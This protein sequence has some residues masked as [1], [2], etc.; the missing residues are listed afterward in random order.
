MFHH[1]IMQNQIEVADIRGR[2]L[3][4]TRIAGQSISSD[5]AGEDTRWLDT[6]TFVARGNQR[7]KHEARR[8]ADFENPGF[9][10]EKSGQVTHSA[11]APQFV[12]GD[13]AFWAIPYAIVAGSCRHEGFKFGGVEFRFLL[14]REAGMKIANVAG[15]AVKNRASAS[16][17]VNRGGDDRLLASS[18]TA[19]WA[20][21]RR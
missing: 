11:L 3:V 6:D 9:W 20:D 10:L 19:E 1:V 7:V 5:V 21:H 12:S 18:G 16:V 14:G 13:V 8:A 15:G 17:A 2:K 4:K